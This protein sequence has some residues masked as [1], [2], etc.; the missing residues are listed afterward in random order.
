MLAIMLMQFL[1]QLNRMRFVFHSFDQALR[2]Q[3]GLFKHVLAGAD[4]NPL[5]QFENPARMI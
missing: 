3:P 2:L 5:F 1:G 4:V